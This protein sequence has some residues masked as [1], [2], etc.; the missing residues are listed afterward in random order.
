MKKREA[1]QNNL[2][3]PIEEL[4]KKSLEYEKSE[5]I[6]P[7]VEQSN[8]SS[9]NN[10]GDIELDL[11]VVFDKD[12]KDWISEF[13]SKEDKSSKLNNEQA[14]VLSA[15]VNILRIRNNLSD[16]LKII[17]GKHVKR[18][19]QHFKVADI[20]KDRANIRKT[21]RLIDSILKNKDSVK[22]LDWC[23]GAAMLFSLGCLTSVYD[24]GAR[25]IRAMKVN[26]AVVQIIALLMGSASFAANWEFSKNAIKDSVH[27]IIGL[28]LKLAG[29]FIFF[30]AF[31]S[32][33]DAAFPLES[34]FKIPESLGASENQAVN[35]TSLIVGIVL[36][37]GTV[38]TMTPIN[39][40]AMNNIKAEIDELK[41]ESDEKSFGVALKEK[42]DALIEKWPYLALLTVFVTCAI[43]RIGAFTKEASET[44]NKHFGTPEGLVRGLQYVGEF[45]LL[46]YSCM[47][48]S[49]TL[50]ESFSKDTTIEGFQRQQ[51]GVELQADK[52][53]FDLEDKKKIILDLTKFIFNATGNGFLTK[54]AFSGI[55]TS[56][57]SL[58][59]CAQDVAASISERRE[60]V[61]I[62]TAETI[63]PSHPLQ[64]YLES[65]L[66]LKIELPSTVSRVIE[67]ATNKVSSDSD[68]VMPRPFISNPRVDQRC[69]I[70]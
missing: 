12:I 35:L 25:K 39:C 24:N 54:D 28:D 43:V 36:G 38:V 57:L 48:L 56:I 11:A 59:I 55:L 67:E 13:L 46:L 33:I 42:F 22:G 16:D 37:I 17:L 15:L 6:F 58:A 63:N 52:K 32:T 50:Y 65:M 31:G 5:D 14:L 26:E 18:I 34:G 1:N 60:L 19:S 20:V 10:E 27:K 41:K 45:T 70:L 8:L 44:Y 30:G 47:Q 23:L 53:N 69:V 2:T 4:E 68:V 7:E 29:L 40:R 51:E 3:E 64:E 61:K 62:L 49:K 9:I 66:K 21:H